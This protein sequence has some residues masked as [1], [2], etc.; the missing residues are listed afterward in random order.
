MV[1]TDIRYTLASAIVRKLWAEGFI[2]EEELKKI[3]EKNA[4]SFLK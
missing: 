4:E 3:L 1:Q 2:T